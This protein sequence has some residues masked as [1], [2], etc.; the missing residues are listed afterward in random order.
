MN[1]FNVVL[2]MLSLFTG[3]CRFTQFNLLAS[4]H[5]LIDDPGCKY[6]SECSEPTWKCCN[7]PCSYKECLPSTVSPTPADIQRQ[8]N[9]FQSS[10]YPRQPTQHLDEQTTNALTRNPATSDYAITTN[11]GVDV[12]TQSASQLTFEM[13]QTNLHTT[14]TPATYADVQREATVQTASTPHHQQTNHGEVTSRLFAENSSTT[15]ERR[16]EPTVSMTTRDNGQHGTA[17][18]SRNHQHSN[19]NNS[20]DQTTVQ[21]TSSSYQQQNQPST[22]AGRSTQH[23]PSNTLANTSNRNDDT[24]TSNT[25]FQEG[26]VPFFDFRFGDTD[27]MNVNDTVF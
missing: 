7:G 11:T 9:T 6:D 15:I 10:G 25:D 26:F 22:E 13:S 23:L 17:Q 4:L 21:Q 19:H 12:I 8:H 24:T 5:C 18:M 14:E 16:I 1:S 3:E 27:H 20:T 2:V